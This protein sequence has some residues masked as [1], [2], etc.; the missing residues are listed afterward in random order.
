MARERERTKARGEDGH[1]ANNVG[2]KPRA[3][4]RQSF[5]GTCWGMG[6]RHE[7]SWPY[8]ETEVDRAVDL[9]E[10]QQ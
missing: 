10:R 8:L 7:T 1:P 4:A 2:S 9:R 3:L 5:S 6:I